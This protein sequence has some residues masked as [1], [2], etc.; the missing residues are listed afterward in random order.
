MWLILIVSLLEA[1]PAAIMLMLIVCMLSDIICDTDTI[2]KI[3]DWIE[4]IVR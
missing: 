2:D 4:K 1:I 3:V